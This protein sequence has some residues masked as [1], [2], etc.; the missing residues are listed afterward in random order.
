VLR[1]AAASAAGREP[2]WWRTT[3]GA[4]REVARGESQPAVVGRY[5]TRRVGRERVLVCLEAPT[6]QVRI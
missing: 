6:L 5:R 1:P 4:L 2:G 3:P